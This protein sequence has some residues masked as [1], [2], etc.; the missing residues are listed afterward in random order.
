MESGQLKTEFVKGNK[1]AFDSVYAQYAGAMYAL[2]KRYTKDLDKAADILQEAFI[3]VYEKRDSF[4]VNYELGPWIKRIVINQAI[5]QYR[6]SKKYDFVEE[7]SYFEEADEEIQLNAESNQNIK[8]ILTKILE[9]LPDGY[10]AVFNMYV[11]DNLT[12]AEIS[13]YLGISVNTS[14][15]QLLKARK[16]IKQK[17]EEYQITHSHINQ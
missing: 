7:D 17:L 9:E 5:N 16:M 4:D 3:K 13:E 14:K 2:C 1:K 11:I 6:F 12:H 10:K 8:L 15:T